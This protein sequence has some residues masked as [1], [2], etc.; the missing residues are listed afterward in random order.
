[1]K[2]SLFIALF[3]ITIATT[4]NAQQVVPVAPVQIEAKAPNTL[5]KEAYLKLNAAGITGETLQ[6]TFPVF[7]EYYTVR[8]KLVEQYAG[9]SINA[10]DEYL[11]LVSN[12]D[13]KLKAI[14]TEGQMKMW[15]KKIEPQLIAEQNL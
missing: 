11:K 9:T 7:F 15:K 2:K 4:A 6:K 10:N 5:T 14:F 12:R 3:A 8:K 13:E 1:M